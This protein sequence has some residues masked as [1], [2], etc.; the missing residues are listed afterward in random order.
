MIQVYDISRSSDLSPTKTKKC[1]KTVTHFNIVGSD[2]LIDVR[3]LGREEATRKPSLSRAAFVQKSYKCMLRVM[4][5]FVGFHFPRK[6][7]IPGSGVGTYFRCRARAQ[8]CVCCAGCVV[9]MIEG[10]R[11]KSKEGSL[12]RE[13]WI[14]SRTSCSECDVGSTQLQC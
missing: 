2:I 9:K 8:F 11:A 10:V 7:L 12:L 4:L 6:M 13:L 5:R 3:T 1:N 14:K